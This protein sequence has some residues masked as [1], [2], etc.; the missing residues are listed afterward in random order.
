MGFSVTEIAAYIGAAAWIPSIA[1]L[2]Y[3]RL[4]KPVVQIIPEKQIELG[5]TTLGPIFNIRLVLSACRKDAIIDNIWVELRHESG[6]E[7][8]LT[9]TGMRETFSEITDMAGNRQLVE[10]DQPAIAIKLATVL[11]TEKFVRFQELAFH[12][13]N[14]PLINAF[15]EHGIYLKEQQND[16]HDSI[17]KSKQLFD[18]MEFYKA[19]FW[20]K[21]G[22]YTVKFG[23][24]GREKVGIDANAFEFKLMQHDIDYLRKNLDIVKDDFENMVK[25]SF[26]PDFESL[27]INWNWRNVPLVKL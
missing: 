18:I 27:P 19:S 8:H 13:R 9:W 15:A 2:L 26:I 10:K 22:R 21:P 11:L 25:T 14:R 23:I 4:V 17:L 6:E 1:Y 20:W 16:C 7:R 24:E 3:G 12:E 5:F